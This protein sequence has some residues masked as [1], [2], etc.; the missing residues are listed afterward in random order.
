[1]ITLTDKAAEKVQEFLSTQGAGVETAGLR[2]GVR[3]GGCSGF[4][5]LLAFDEQRD[6]DTVVESHG[7]PPARRRAEPRL[8]PR[9]DRR[10]PRRPSGRGL[11]GRE[12][13]RHRRVRLRLLLPRRRRGR[14]LG[15]LSRSGRSARCARHPAPRCSCA[16]R[17]R[18][19]RAAR[20]RVDLGP[21]RAGV[22]PTLPD[23]AARRGL[24]RRRAARPGHGRWDAAPERDPAT[25]RP[26]SFMEMPL[27]VHLGA[28]APRAGAG[29]GAE[30]LR[31]AAGLDARVR[32]VRDA[33]PASDGADDAARGARLPRRPAA[34]AGAP[35]RGRSACPRRE[36]RRNQRLLWTWDFLSLAVCLDWA[37]GVARGVPSAQGSED[38]RLA[39]DGARAAA[40]SASPSTPGHSR[41]GRSS[42]AVTVG[43]CRVASRTRP[44]CTTPWL[45]LRGSPCAGSSCPRQGPARRCRVGARWGFAPCSSASR[46]RSSVPPQPGRPRRSCRSQRSSRGCGAPG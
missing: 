27:D 41:S 19:H 35:A 17:R 32:A 45:R 18:L 34:V 6:G 11:Q 26:Y 23:R 5:Y 22:G 24:P 46:S 13:E 1:M 29:A 21:A 25:G 39:S 28:L 38:L 4:Q 8:R 10:L 14:G 37:P 43:A 9:L 33:R 15:G 31:R 7:H 44:R 30:P 40:R 2:V 3:G 36:A 42:F 16:G 12:P 20:A